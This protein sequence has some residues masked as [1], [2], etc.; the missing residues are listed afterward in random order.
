[1]VPPPTPLLPR[2]AQRGPQLDQVDE[3]SLILGVLV[4]LSSM[5]VDTWTNVMKL[6]GTPNSV[7]S[8]NMPMMGMPVGFAR[9]TDVTSVGNI[10][11]Q[12]ILC[13][14]KRRICKQCPVHIRVVSTDWVGTLFN[15][16]A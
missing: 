3:H 9:R 10:V 14:K 12:E 4:C 7:P 11:R 2:L 6:P 13:D 8:A 15:E 5:D 16:G 1:V